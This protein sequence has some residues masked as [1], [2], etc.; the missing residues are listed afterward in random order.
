MSG[1]TTP[2]GPAADLP[3][4]SPPALH[5]R[6]L[7]LLR[8]SRPGAV[9]RAFRDRF[10]FTE[11]YLADLDAIAGAPPALEVYAAIRELGCRLWVDAGLHNESQA[12]V[13]AATGVE[14]IVAGLETISG[15]DM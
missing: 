13:L 15:P 8:P 4:D 1:S 6:S 2:C 5:S 10:G 12:R 11:F 3:H 14:V 9:A 7:T